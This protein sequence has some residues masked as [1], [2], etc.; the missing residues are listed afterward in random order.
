MKTS[1]LHAGVIVSITATIFFLMGM[2]LRPY[3]LE[4]GFFLLGRFKKNEIVDSKSES[5]LETMQPMGTIDRL[6]LINQDQVVEERIRKVQV[7]HKHLENRLEHLKDN[8]NMTVGTLELMSSV[9]VPAPKNEIAPALPS[10][11][12]LKEIYGI[13]LHTEEV[14]REKFGIKTF[15][16]I[17][18]LNNHQ[19]EEIIEELYPYGGRENLDDWIYQASKLTNSSSAV[20]Q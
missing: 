11:D 20:Y 17:T 8:L 14:L 1:F 5:L 9:L 4:A 15:A 12:N 16:Q 3:I 7:N 2:Y 19:V 18:K 10:N 13:G 6:I